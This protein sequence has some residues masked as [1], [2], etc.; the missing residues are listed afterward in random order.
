LVSSDGDLRR[1]AQM[2]DLHVDDW[3]VPGPVIGET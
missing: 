1:I 2:V 3:H